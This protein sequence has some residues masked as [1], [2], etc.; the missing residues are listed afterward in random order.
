MNELQ[1]EKAEIAG[2]LLAKDASRNGGSLVGNQTGCRRRRGRNRKLNNLLCLKDMRGSNAS[3]RGA[4]V[5]GLGQLNKVHAQCICAT[6]EHWDLNTD[7]RVL[8]L[9]GGDH[10][11]LCL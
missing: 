9:V 6:K 8:P 3:T 11:L 7:A 4:D 10:R 1:P 2:R 5:E